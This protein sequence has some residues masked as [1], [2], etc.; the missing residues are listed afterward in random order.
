MKKKKD[1]GLG[2]SEKGLVGLRVVIVEEEE[3]LLSLLSVVSL[4][5]ASNGNQIFGEKTARR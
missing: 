4:L 2:G 3:L 1:A 5:S